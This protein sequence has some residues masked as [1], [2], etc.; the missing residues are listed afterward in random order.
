MML[1]YL[2]GFASVWAAVALV[3]ALVAAYM[4]F[5]RDWDRAF[6]KELHVST[7]VEN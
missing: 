2:L 3:S 7:T 4:Y 6:E 5:G 1:M